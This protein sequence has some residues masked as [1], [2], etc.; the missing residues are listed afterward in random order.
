[1]R[2]YIEKSIFSGSTLWC[3][4]LWTTWTVK[5][6]GCDRTQTLNC[7]VVDMMFVIHVRADLYL[8]VYTGGGFIYFNVHCYFSRKSHL[9]LFQL[10]WNTAW[11][12]ISSIVQYSSAS[13]NSEPWAML[14]ACLSKARRAIHLMTR[15]G[16]LEVLRV[17]TSTLNDQWWK[18]RSSTYWSTSIS[19]DLGE[20]ADNIRRRT[21]TRWRGRIEAAGH[22]DWGESPW[23]RRVF[24]A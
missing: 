16:E 10:G 24:L 2:H 19:V 1:M 6:I 22:L 11:L 23:T 8:Y 18:H 15:R 14:K 12:Y 21:T 9:R 17:L 20:W 5:N 13:I 7:D 3:T 4:F